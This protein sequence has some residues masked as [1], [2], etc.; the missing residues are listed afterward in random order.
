MQARY[1]AFLNTGNPNPSGS[2]YATWNAATSASDVSALLLGGT[3]TEAVGACTV[4][5]WG[6]ELQYD[7][8]VF[9]I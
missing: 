1:K 9:G 2:S 8:Q 6:D 7:Y 4:D 5:F 3:G